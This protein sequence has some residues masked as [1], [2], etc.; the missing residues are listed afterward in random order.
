[1]NLA[2]CLMHSKKTYLSYCYSVV[3]IFIIRTL[4]LVLHLDIQW[5]ICHFSRS[6]K[7]RRNPQT[8]LS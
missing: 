7:F 3:I 2:P 8:P 6:C 4:G 5:V 1:M